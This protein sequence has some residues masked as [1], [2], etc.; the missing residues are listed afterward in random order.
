M[1]L[2]S[3]VLSVDLVRKM[4][5]HSRGFPSIF[6]NF[7]II[8][9]LS[10]K[11]SHAEWLNVKCSVLEELAQWELFT[12]VVTG[13]RCLKHLRP[14]KANSQRM[15]MNTLDVGQNR[16]YFFSDL[17]LIY[18]KG[19]GRKLNKWLN[20]L[21][22]TS[23]LITTTL[24]KCVR[25]GFSTVTHF[26][27]K[28]GHSLCCLSFFATELCREVVKLVEVIFKSLLSI[29]FFLVQSVNQ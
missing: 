7:Y 24:R 6:N 3:A 11:Q 21:C 15:V 25:V 29:L 22:D 8:Q 20:W 28:H 23:V 26:K 14:L 19:S 9:S 4:R 2:F 13:T 1:L 10:R 17:Q 18:V 12:A 27:S 16:T 5:L